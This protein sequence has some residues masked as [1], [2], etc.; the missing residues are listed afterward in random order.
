MTSMRSLFSRLAHKGSSAAPVGTPK[1]AGCVSEP[2]GNLETGLGPQ[3]GEFNNTATLQDIF[4]CFRLLLGRNPNPEEWPGHSSRVGEDLDNVVS[5]YITS[6]EF[7]ARNLM[8][9]TYQNHVELIRLPRFSLFASREDLAVGRYVVSDHSYEP[10]IS[11]L[12]QRYVQPGMAVIDIGANIGYLTMLLASLVEQSGLVIAVEPNPENVRLLE[13]SRRVNGFPHI[14]VLELA[15][16]RDTG[17]LALNT[18]HSNG[19]AGDLPAD[20]GSLLRSRLVPCFALDAILPTNRRI[21][22]IKLDAEGAE[23]NALLGL[24]E[25]IARDLPIIVSEFS[26]GALPGISH[27]TGPEYLNFLIARGYRIG[28]IRPDG[29]ENWFGHDVSGVMDAYARSGIDHIDIVAH[30]ATP[31]D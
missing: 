5:S 22:L 4:Y 23:Y 19:V 7:S 31:C 10:G 28:V 16:G 27:C 1:L 25:T 18:S 15:A 6:R 29:S 8:D 24:S 17:L 26:P 12:L 3:F 11:A 21:S 2:N 14:A 20:V 9:K 30:P 13:A